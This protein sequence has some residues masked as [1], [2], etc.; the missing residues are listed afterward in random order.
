MTGKAMTIM[1]V[2]ERAFVI[3]PEIV[4]GDPTRNSLAI[5]GMTVE[6]FWSAYDKPPKRPRPSP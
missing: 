1:I 5:T 3:G 6:K 4:L 2:G